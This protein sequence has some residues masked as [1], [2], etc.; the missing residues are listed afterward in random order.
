MGKTAKK[1]EVRAQQA[2][3]S[4]P[5]K[6]KQK[7]IK[8]QKKATQ[9]QTRAVEDTVKKGLQ[10]ESIFDQLNDSNQRGQQRSLMAMA[11]V[12]LGPEMPHAMFYEASK[13]V[14]FRFLLNVI[15]C[16]DDRTSA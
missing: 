16:R 15:D 8:K 12:S 10:G 6:V 9:V 7:F 11:A 13:S 5:N 3:A 1:S 4:T 14:H 2:A